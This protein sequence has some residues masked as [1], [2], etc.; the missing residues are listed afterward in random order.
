MKCVIPRFST[1]YW[2][3]AFLAF[4]FPGRSFADGYTAYYRCNGTQEA[5]LTVKDNKLSMV[6]GLSKEGANKQVISSQADSLIKISR[7]WADFFPANT[8]NQP[9]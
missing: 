8:S 1:M 9:I 4:I 3:I 6:V 7:I 2:L 5:S